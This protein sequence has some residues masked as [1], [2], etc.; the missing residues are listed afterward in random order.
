ME[1]HEQ[2]KRPLKHII[3]NNFVGG[4]SWALG[5]A[6]GGTVVIAIL[7]LIFSKVNLIPVV[8]TFVSQITTFVLQNNSHLI[9]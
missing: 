5:V 8:G 2:V 7:G 3:I 9:K 1:Q 4:I 6:I